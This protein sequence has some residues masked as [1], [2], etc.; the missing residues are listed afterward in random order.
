VRKTP[1]SCQHCG[2]ALVLDNIQRCPACR[3]KVPPKP[4]NPYQ[5]GAVVKSAFRKA[6]IKPLVLV[7]DEVHQD[8]AKDSSRGLAAAWFAD[9]FEKVLGVSGSLYGGKHS[10]IFHL[11]Y[12]LIPSFRAQWGVDDVGAFVH[13]YASWA[14]YWIDERFDRMVELPGISPL[15]MAGIL[16]NH[17]IF[18]T[19][20][21][22]GF[23]LPE[24]TDIPVFVEMGMSEREAAG[25]LAAAVKA[26]LETEGASAEKRVSVSGADLAKLQAHPVG[27]H[28]PQM[29]PF[30]P[31]WHCPQCGE[32]HRPVGACDHPWQPLGPNGETAAIE[33]GPVSVL[34]PVLDPNWRSRKEAHLLGLVTNE[35]AEGRAC[36][37][38]LWNTGKAYRID[39]RIEALLK[40]AGVRTLNAS[41]LPARTVQQRILASAYEGVQAVLVNP[42]RVG[43]GTNL[44]NLPTIIFYQPVWSVYTAAQAASR[45]HRPTQQRDVRVYWMISASSVEEVILSRIIE[46]MVVSEYVAGGDTDG[47]AAVLE[48]VGHA[49]TFEEAV[50]NHI[51]Q[52]AHE[53]VGELLAHH[54]NALCSLVS[55]LNEVRGAA[56]TQGVFAHL[57]E[58]GVEAASSVIHERVLAGD[59][60]SARQLS[61]F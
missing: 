56:E 14:K 61:F 59:L 19:L 36:L 8:R 24:R 1:W 31:A 4:A 17:T 60:K 7:N 47:Y 32:N 57:R 23:Q 21:D 49:E 38:Y 42:R 5:L 18:L 20:Q 41:R 43:T 53:N 15:V 13:R 51:R 29:A 3:G 10:T 35:N 6:D 2:H 22:A 46:K 48:A 37:I 44:V 50:F 40:D 9:L 39:R 52:F 45:S 33:D 55:Q 16:L 34:K 30:S 11:L 27:M 26:R 12:R 28:L 54:K 25:A 58:G